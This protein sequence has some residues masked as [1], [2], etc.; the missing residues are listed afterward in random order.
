MADISKAAA[1]ARVPAASSSGPKPTKTLEV[2]GSGP[3]VSGPSLSAARPSAAKPSTTT[4]TSVAAAASKRKRRD[5]ASGS[6]QE[7]SDDDYLSEKL[8]PANQESGG[9]KGEEE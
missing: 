3:G 2:R 7:A 4:G 9:V 8:E 1:A 5:S 6:E